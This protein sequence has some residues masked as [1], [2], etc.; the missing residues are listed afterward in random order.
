M[1]KV[2]LSFVKRDQF[3][4]GAD[5]YIGPSGNVICPVAATVAFTAVRGTSAGPFF[6]SKSGRPLQKSHFIAEVRRALAALSLSSGDY[7]GHSFR[8]GTATATAAA[9]IQDSTIQ[10]LRRWSSA[11]FLTYVRTPHQDLATVSVAVAHIA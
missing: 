7:A 10:M 9:G 5:I 1:V 2:H 4:R 6:R 8:I 11:A 3:G